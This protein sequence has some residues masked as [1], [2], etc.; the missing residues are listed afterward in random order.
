MA[1]VELVDR[2]IRDVNQQ[3]VLI[4]DHI[5]EDPN[6]EMSRFERRLSAITAD[7]DAAKQTYVRY[8]D[9]P[10][11]AVAW[12]AVLTM[13]ARFDAATGHILSLSRRNLDVEARVESR[14][15]RADYRKLDD[16]FKE[17]LRAN[18]AEAA[19]AMQRIENLR[20]TT[21]VAVLGCVSASCWPWASWLVGRATHLPLR[22]P[23]ARICRGAGGS[24]PQPRRLRRSR[25]PRHQ[26]HAGT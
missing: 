22:E 1:G 23:P 15:M 14:I 17:L 18:R 4:D 21:D 12:R 25:G 26:E 11:E 5:D 9:L 3:R 2:I 7:L 19:A 20:R 6:P 16:Q 24:E 8:V 13:L 10:N